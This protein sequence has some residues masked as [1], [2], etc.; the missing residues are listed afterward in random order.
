AVAIIPLARVHPRAISVANDKQ[1]DITIDLQDLHL[2]SA[3]SGDSGGLV[4]QAD[5][6]TMRRLREKLAREGV[7]PEPGPGGALN[8]LLDRARNLADTMQNKLRG[9]T[10]HKQRLNLRLADNDP[11]FASNNQ[12]SKDANAWR[13]PHRGDETGQFKHEEQQNDQDA[14]LPPIEKSPRNPAQQ[15]TPATLGGGGGG[16]LGGGGDIQSQASSNDSGEEA[17]SLRG[18]GASNSGFSHGIGADPDSLFGEPVNTRMGNEGFEIAIEARP[19]EQGAKGAGQA[20]L[21]P[22]VRTPLNSN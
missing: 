11:G 17:E 20:Y 4:V 14:P 13:S 5:P 21:P 15:P 6:A 16:E 18:E 2:R 9:Q 1:E 3:D 22:K 19:I 10:T 12:N 7:T 8:G